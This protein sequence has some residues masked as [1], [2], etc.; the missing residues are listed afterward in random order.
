MESSTFALLGASLL[1]GGVLVGGAAGTVP[2]I[3]LNSIGASIVGGEDPSNGNQGD[4]DVK[5]FSFVALC[6]DGDEARGTDSVAATGF[7]NE[8]ESEPIEVSWSSATPVDYVVYKAGPPILVVDVDGSTGGT[9]TSGEGETPSE[10]GDT[11]VYASNPCGEGNELV[12][13][14]WTGDSFVAESENGGA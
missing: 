9:I 7:N 13:Y 12:K 8:G 5:A 4:A 11:T 3:G 2:G 10:I 14:E 6:T 1:I